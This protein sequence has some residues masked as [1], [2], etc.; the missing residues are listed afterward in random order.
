MGK[1][2]TKEALLFLK[3]WSLQKQEAESSLIKALKEYIGEEF[4]FPE[5]EKLLKAIT[6]EYNFDPFTAK[7][8]SAKVKIGKEILGE[9]ELLRVNWE[10]KLMPLNFDMHSPPV[11]ELFEKLVENFFEL[12]HEVDIPPHERN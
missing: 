1:R 5:L 6:F 3:A 7:S 2:F 12:L 11:L 8:V 10:G 4:I 9:V